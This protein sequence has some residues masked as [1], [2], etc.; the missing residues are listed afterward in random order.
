MFSTVSPEM[1]QKFLNGVR[2]SIHMQKLVR[3]IKQF[4]KLKF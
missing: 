2:K 4:T 1:A 3:K